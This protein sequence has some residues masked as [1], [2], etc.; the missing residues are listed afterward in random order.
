[1]LN[2]VAVLDLCIEPS[3]SL[4]YVENGRLNLLI[5]SLP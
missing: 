1:M 4:N 5:F 2:R 3:H